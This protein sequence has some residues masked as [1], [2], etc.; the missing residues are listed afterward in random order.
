MSRLGEKATAIRPSGGCRVSRVVRGLAEAI[1]TVSGS[2]PVQAAHG[3]LVEVTKA[4]GLEPIREDANIRCRGRGSGALRHAPPPGT[5]GR[6]IEIAQ[7]RDLV[8]K[9]ASIDQFPRIAAQYSNSCIH[10]TG[11][12]SCCFNIVWVS[13]CVEA[14]WQLL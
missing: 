14:T 10:S 11:V 13:N 4:F 1:A 5:Q 9:L 2:Y 7:P 3:F 8:F 12:G 6:K